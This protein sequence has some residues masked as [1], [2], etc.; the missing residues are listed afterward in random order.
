MTHQWE[1]TQGWQSMLVPE[2]SR[3]LGGG[4]ESA[5]DLRAQA[6][7][8]SAIACLNAATDAWTTDDGKTPL[9]LLVDQAMGTLSELSEENVT[10]H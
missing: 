5:N 3:R 9:S 6:L 1:K 8:A 2:I 7:A 10:G 4:P